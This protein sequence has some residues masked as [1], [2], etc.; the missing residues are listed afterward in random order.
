MENQPT[1]I[2]EKVELAVNELALSL[3]PDNI[4]YLRFLLGNN[5]VDSAVVHLFQFIEKSDAIVSSSLEETLSELKLHHDKLKAAEEELLSIE[6]SNEEITECVYAFFK[7]YKME[8]IVFPESIVY[9]KDYFDKKN[10]PN[11]SII[12]RLT[13]P[14][15][16]T[17][18]EV[19]LFVTAASLDVDLMITNA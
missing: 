10:I 8:A 4:Y 1:N 2:R 13:P 11:W 7:K 15:S 3:S 16:Q 9:S 17:E 6:V 5:F 18:R 14:T 12:A 19:K